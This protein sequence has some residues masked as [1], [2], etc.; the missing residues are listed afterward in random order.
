MTSST[1]NIYGEVSTIGDVRD[2]NQQIRREMRHVVS[3]PEL[4]EL[5]KRSDYLC[6]LTYAPSWQTKFGKKV[7][8][9]REVAKEE[10]AR[11]TRLANELASR[12]NLGEADYDA[13]QGG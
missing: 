10:D 4:T 2:I 7:R 5:K 13:W 1:S 8:R 12:R 3:R 6:T 9:F 11:T